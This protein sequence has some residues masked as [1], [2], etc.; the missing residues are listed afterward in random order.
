MFFMSGRLLHIR[1]HER[2]THELCSVPGGLG[3]QRHELRL[4]VPGGD[5]LG[6]AGRIELHGVR[7]RHDV[8][9]GRD[10]VRVL[11]RRD[12]P[13]GERLRGVRLRRSLQHKQSRE[14]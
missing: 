13:L 9:L 8:G 10:A 1:R 12:I 5:V 4:R 7:I 3:V 11:S 6:G 2:N 14:L